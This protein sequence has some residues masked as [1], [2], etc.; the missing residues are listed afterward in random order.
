MQGAIAANAPRGGTQVSAT[1]RGVIARC[2]G[3]KNG[4]YVIVITDGK[5]ADKTDVERLVLDEIAPHLNPDNPNAVRLHFIGAGDE[6][7]RE[8]LER[9][10]TQAA[11]RG[12]A[13][14]RQHR[15]RD[16]AFLPILKTLDA[17]YP[18]GSKI[19]NIGRL[20]R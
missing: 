3:H 7:D 4:I 5:F 17:R 14:V 13:L 11:A 19:A 6:V 20:N 2:R 8:F 1:L 9:L 16:S 12:V 10:E 18:S 15:G